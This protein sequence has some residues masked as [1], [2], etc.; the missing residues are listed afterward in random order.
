M[1]VGGAQFSPRRA[2]QQR[3][4]R[5]SAPGIALVRTGCASIRAAHAHG[6]DPGAR[7]RPARALTTMHYGHMRTRERLGSRD[8]SCCMSREGSPARLAG[9]RGCAK[10][11]GIRRLDTC[12]TTCN[13]EVRIYRRCISARSS[14]WGLATSD[15]AD[16]LPPSALA[17]RLRFSQQVPSLTALWVS[18]PRLALVSAGNKDLSLEEMQ[19]PCQT[20]PPVGIR[21]SRSGCGM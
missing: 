5:W 11:P 16:R 4:P 3:L 18:R 6:S 13:A 7:K 15:A 19:S 12:S 8:D 14:G 2:A 17:A 1:G 10:S 9:E 21:S 20:L